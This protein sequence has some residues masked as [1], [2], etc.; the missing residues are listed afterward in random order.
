MRQKAG[1]H[2][3]VMCGHGLCNKTCLKDVV[4]YVLPDGHQA[5]LC[6]NGTQGLASLVPHPA[7]CAAG[8]TSGCRKG[9]VWL[10]LRAAAACA[11]SGLLHGPRFCCASRMLFM[12]LAA[13]SHW[14][15]IGIVEDVC[16]HLNRR[17]VLPL[18]QAESHIVSEQR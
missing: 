17:Q 4:V 14:V 7:M 3:N 18:A 8:R 12:C 10:V 16:E 1:L 2:K 11:L 5:L 6:T 13:R 9:P 15:L